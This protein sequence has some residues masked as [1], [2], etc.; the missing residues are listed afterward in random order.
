MLADKFLELKAKDERA[1]VCYITAGDPDLHQLPAIIDCLQSSGADIIEV[2][3]PFSDPIGDGPTIQASSQRALD[4]GVTPEAI[5]EVL[6][7]S[8]F[9]VPVVLMGYYNTVLRI[10]FEA[11]VKKA[12]S[13]GICGMIL[14]DITPEEADDWITICR[15]NDFATIFLAAPTSTDERL[16]LVAK[17]ASGFVYAVSR[18][19]VT[20]ANQQ[21]SSNVSSLVKR[22]K[23]RTET[24]V[25]VGFGISKPEH[26]REVCQSADG[27]VVGS[28]LVT[29]LHESWHLPNGPEL[30]QNA[31]GELKKATYNQ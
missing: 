24:P 7:K 1:L 21:F 19:G 2:G 15:Q 31:I 22:L 25:C 27:A 16:D 20:G 18:T 10:G 17:S 4:K 8:S 26:V 3:V 9:K 12:K 6:S 13:I 14:V 23:D 11:F 29:M 28:Y 30:V 5:F